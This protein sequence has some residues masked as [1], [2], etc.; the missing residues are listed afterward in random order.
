MMSWSST[1]PA[2]P[3]SP[4]HPRPARLL[5]AARH[6]Q[7]RISP[8]ATS[9]G[10]PTPTG[11]AA[12][13]RRRPGRRRL[14]LRLPRRRFRPRRLARHRPAPGADHRGR[15]D[16]NGLDDL[17]VRNAGDGTLSVYFEQPR[18][19]A[20]P[21][22]GVRSPIPAAV[23]LPVGPGVS[24]VQA[25]DTTGDGRLDLVVTNKLTGQVS[26][27]PQPGRWRLRPARPLSRRD[28]VVRRSIPAATPEVTSLEATAGVAAG[29]LT[30]G[31]PTDLV[32]IN[33]GS[34]TLDVLAGLGGGRFAN[35]VDDRD[36]EPRP[37]GPHGRLQPRRHRR[38]GR[39]HRRW[40]EHLSRQRQRRLL[41]PGDL[42]CRH[43]SHRPDR[44]RPAGQR[45]ARPP[46]RQ[47]LWRRADPR[48]QRR[49]HLPALRAGEGRHRPGR[50]RPHRQRRP[51]LRLRRPVAQPG[52]GRLRHR[53]PERQQP[54]RSSATR[55][56]ACSPPAPS[57]WPT[58]TATASP[59]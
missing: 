48:R 45:P 37:G 49:R 12:G 24:D 58:S 23:T 1:A 9:P 39:P 28:R 10:C 33:P 36:P 25:I 30:P 14:A 53:R 38:P 4:G 22:T 17:V 34:N 29:P 56:P 20:A 26:V 52:L 51:R 43:R 35:P 8:P 6:G 40:R 47:R 59:T 2:N 31:G 5:P 27:L 44:R 42:Q 21:G 3:L 32:T 11:P 54:G 19:P 16:G 50:R 15:P 7:P 55:P 18:S 41:A 13:Q 46:G 57:C